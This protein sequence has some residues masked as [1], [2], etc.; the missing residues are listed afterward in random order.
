MLS[1]LVSRMV[2]PCG[3]R[4][5]QWLTSLAAPAD[6]DSLIKQLKDAA[7]KAGLPADTAE[8]WLKSKAADGKVDAEEMVGRRRAED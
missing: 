2:S 3:L 5:M 8:Y 7:N 6:I 4:S 1:S